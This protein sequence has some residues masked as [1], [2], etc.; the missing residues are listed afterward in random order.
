MRKNILLTLMVL[1]S[2]ALTAQ[3]AIGSFTA[4][5]AMHAFSS[6]AVDATTVY[7]A[8]DNGLM[9]LEK[10]SMYEEHTEISSWSMVGGVSDNEIEGVLHVG[11]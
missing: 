2:F 10:G 11:H 8:T 6:V 1:S 7:A 3:T 9:L 5:T 4:H